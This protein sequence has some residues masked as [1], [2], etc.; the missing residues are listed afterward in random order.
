MESCICGSVVQTN[1]VG[2]PEYD[3][4]CRSFG[5]DP[6]CPACSLQPWSGV[7]VTQ[8]APDRDNDHF[9]VHWKGQ[10]VPWYAFW[11]GDDHLTAPDCSG[12]TLMEAGLA[13]VADF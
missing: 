12:W 8:F 9:S 13:T 4:D 6:A 5:C 1:A 11:D 2:E 3:G 10:D 7:T